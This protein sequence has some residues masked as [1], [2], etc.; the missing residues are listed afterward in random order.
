MTFKKRL[1][2]LSALTVVVAVALTVIFV[3]AR[4]LTAAAAKP[5]TVSQEKMIALT[6]DDGPNPVTTPQLLKELE[7]AHA[8]ATFFE[9]GKNVEKYP[10]VTKAVAADGNDVAS[11]TWDHIDMTTLSA[12]T[13]K[14]E[15]DKAADKI[16]SITGKDLN[17]Y[18]PPEGRHD[19]TTLAAEPREVVTWSQDTGDWATKNTAETV[20]Y[21]TL[22]PHDGE[23]VL[24][25]DIY[26]Q[27]VAAVPEIIKTLRAKG[28]TLVTVSQ[29]IAAHGGI[30][31]HSSYMVTR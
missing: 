5:K 24:M 27:T 15:V 25:H 12:S 1:A 7:A 18:R 29:L 13:A 30:H 6:F 3:N 17:F 20:H 19:A 23:I 22:N 26:P 11:H 14:N 9:I 10:E 16:A 2:V 8:H 28:Y 31:E 21:A 4:M